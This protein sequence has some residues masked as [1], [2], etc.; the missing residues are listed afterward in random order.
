MRDGA[1]SLARELI[2]AS[3]AVPY[4]DLQATTVAGQLQAQPGLG[5]ATAA[6]RWHVVRRNIEYTVTSTL[7][8]VDAGK[9]GYGDHGGDSFCSDSTTTGTADTNPDD[10]K[11]VAVD[12]SWSSNGR[13]VNVRQE[14]VINDPGSAFAP[15]GHRD[16]GLDDE[17]HVPT[18]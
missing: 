15:V 1:T 4:P 2:E 14:A 9:D 13:T 16:E 3:R 5:D 8:S 10:Y 7:C 17:R 6:A 12:V 18:A 11:R